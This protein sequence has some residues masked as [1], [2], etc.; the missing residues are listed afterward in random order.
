VGKIYNPALVFLHLGARVPGMALAGAL[1]AVVAVLSRL[2]TAAAAAPRRVLQPACAC[3]TCVSKGQYTV[4][5]CASFGLDCSCYGGTG[6]A[7]GGGGYAMQIGDGACFN[8]VDRTAAVNDECCNEKTEDCSS[9][10]PAT[11]NLGCAHVL[12]PFFDDCAGVLGTAGAAQLDGIV[13]LCRAA[14]AAAPP[15]RHL[16]SRPRLA[17]DRHAVYVSSLSRADAGMPRALS[18]LACMIIP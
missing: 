10:R 15:V 4:A 12:L 6:P 13:V 7:T 3:A 18:L 1:L 2:P 8:L 17:C 11:C 5:D 14:E 9:G 16:S